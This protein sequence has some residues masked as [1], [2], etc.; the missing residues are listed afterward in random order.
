M[1]REESKLVENRFCDT[2]LQQ[3][4]KFLG[5]YRPT[6]IVSLR[7]ITLVSLKKLQFLMRFHA[8]SNDPQVQASAHADDGRH[9]GHLPRNGG[10]LG[11]GDTIVGVG[12]FTAF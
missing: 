10:D 8:F 1:V 6:E 7:F 5:D 3:L 11:P 4:G 9:D 12:G 2:G